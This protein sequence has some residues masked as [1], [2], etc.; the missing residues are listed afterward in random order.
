MPTSLSF[1]GIARRASAVASLQTVYGGGSAPQGWAIAYEANV[2]KFF[3]AGQVACAV[4]A[5]YPN[6]DASHHS[7]GITID[8]ATAPFLIRGYFDGSVVASAQGGSWGGGTQGL[9]FAGHRGF[10]GSQSFPGLLGGEAALFATNVNATTMKRLHDSAFAPTGG[11][12]TPLIRAAEAFASVSVRYRPR[13][14]F[15]KGV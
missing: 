4:G 5:S 2:L 9:Y 14:L 6:P 3:L 13:F 1:F 12:T 8:G 7:Y 10:P 15:L 11:A